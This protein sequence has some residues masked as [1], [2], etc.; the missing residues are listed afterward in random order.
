MDRLI[1][2]LTQLSL[3]NV[4]AKFILVRLNFIGGP[5]LEAWSTSGMQI[6]RPPG[7]P[8]RTTLALLCESGMLP[9]TYT[10][11][12]EASLSILFHVPSFRFSSNF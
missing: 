7:K 2:V 5:C 6:C 1:Y 8:M 9:R 4:A 3:L 10:L 12:L 11:A